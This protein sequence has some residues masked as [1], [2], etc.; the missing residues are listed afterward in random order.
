M[1]GDQR[2]S[3]VKLARAQLVDERILLVEPRHHKQRSEKKI[4]IANDNGENI[5]LWREFLL[6]WSRNWPIPDDRFLARTG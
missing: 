1:T 6:L 2:E 3:F 4:F 5:T